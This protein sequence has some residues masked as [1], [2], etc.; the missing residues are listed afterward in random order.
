M[1]ARAASAAPFERI[2]HGGPA[3]EGVSIDQVASRAEVVSRRLETAY[4]DTNRN[5]RFTL[6]ALGEGWGVRLATRRMLRQL[7]GGTKHVRIRK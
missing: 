1:P 4:P 5:R 3:A 7:A 6:T 2:E